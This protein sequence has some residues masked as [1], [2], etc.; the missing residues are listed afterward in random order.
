LYVALLSAFPKSVILATMSARL[1]VYI[2]GHC[3]TCPDSLEVVRRVRERYP[4]IGVETLDV[5]HEP[6]REEVFAVPTYLFDGTVVFLGNP[7]NEE[8]D[9]LLEGCT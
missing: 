9:R 1:I 4:G 3:P 7:T 8:V 2:S 6:P 5:D